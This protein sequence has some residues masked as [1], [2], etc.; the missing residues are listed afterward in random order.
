MCEQCVLLPCWSISCLPAS[1]GNFSPLQKW[2]D[3][4]LPK[5][6][7]P[8]AFQDKAIVLFVS[9]FH[10][11]G[12]SPSCELSY[13]DVPLWENICT[14]QTH[15]LQCRSFLLFKFFPLTWQAVLYSVLWMLQVFTVVHRE[16]QA[17]LRH[18][19]FS[20]QCREAPE[21]PVGCPG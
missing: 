14:P 13:K 11:L 10:N 3:C 4:S 1:G 20:L 6:S 21:I 12:E 17:E 15:F 8:S 19:I 9:L 16:H 5:G 18:M 7:F 2:I